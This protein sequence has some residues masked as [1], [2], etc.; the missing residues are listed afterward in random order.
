MND[1]VKLDAFTFG[2]TLRSV[3]IS[4]A[5]GEEPRIAKST[6]TSVDDGY[7]PEYV[8]IGKSGPRLSKKKEK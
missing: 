7:K 2:E 6:T 5:P 1:F 3:G 8:R 4:Q